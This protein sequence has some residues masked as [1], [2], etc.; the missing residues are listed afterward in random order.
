MKNTHGGVLLLAKLQAATHHTYQEKNC[1]HYLGNIII[2]EGVPPS[3]ELLRNE[4][5]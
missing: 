1:I 5:N 4:Q 3:R 2:G